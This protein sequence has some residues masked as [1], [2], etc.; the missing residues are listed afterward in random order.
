MHTYPDLG[1]WGATRVDHT[2]RH[3]LKALM[4]QAG[5]WKH[6]QICT[7]NCNQRMCHPNHVTRVSPHSHQILQNRLLIWHYPCWVDTAKETP[8]QYCYAGILQLHGLHQ[9]R[10]HDSERLLP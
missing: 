4:L 10:K 8:K 5:H 2:P 1:F 9:A 3:V 6:A 7:C